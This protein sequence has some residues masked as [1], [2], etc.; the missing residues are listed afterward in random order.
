MGVRR[1]LPPALIGFALFVGLGAFDDSHVWSQAWFFIG[2]GLFLSATFVEPFFSRPQDSIVNA[3]GGIG[4]F[5]GVERS[6]IEGLW[7]AYL[8]CM[9]VILL[10][11]LAATVMSDAA[12]LPK[13][14]SFRIASRFGRASVIGTAALLLVVLQEAAAKEA[15]FEYLAA[16]TAFLVAGVAV[17]WPSILSRVRQRAESASA[18]AAIGPRMLLATA[19]G[20]TNFHEGDAL[21]VEAQGNTVT[22]SVVARLPHRDGLRYQIALSSDWTEICSTF[23]DDLILRARQDHAELIGAVSEG[24]TNLSVTFEPFQ[25]LEIGSPVSLHIDQR[26]L[27]YQVAQL[28]LVSSSWAGASAVVGEATAQIVGWPE[29]DGTIR[30]GSYLPHPHELIYRAEGLAQA[31]P[32]GFYEIGFIKGTA[33]PIGLRVDDERRGHI[34]VLGM[35]GMGKTAVAQR[36]C[37]TL[38]ATNVVVALDTTG[39]YANR[40]GFPAFADDLG[41]PGYSVHEPAGDPPE[42]AAAFIRQCMEAGAAEY[43]DGAPLSSRVVLLEEAHSFVPEWNFALRGQQDHVAYSTRMIMQA[44]KFGITFVIVSQRTAVV[45]KS[46]LS[47]CENYIILKTI[48][49]TSLDYLES[50]VGHEMRQ[51]IPSLRRYEAICVGPAFNAEEPVIVVLSPP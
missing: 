41:T 32:A 37:R 18:V 14:A 38:G 42:R 12:G 39:E 9:I 3:A 49:Q 23:P 26:T 29:A 51:A 6:P 1:R 21:T 45:S 46:A 40:L 22:G 7:F 20:S 36:I 2:L 33:I 15:G 4:A 28:R 19:A 43:R 10:C 44:R 50:V 17:D 35:S 31:L 48:D 34:A 8:A 30:G 24:T 16:G 5:V 11:G 13:W 27:L 47:Q 25:A